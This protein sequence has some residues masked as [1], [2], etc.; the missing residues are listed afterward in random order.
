MFNLNEFI[1]NRIN[2]LHLVLCMYSGIGWMSQYHSKILVF[3]L[4]GMMFNWLLDD[5][6]CWM[7]RLEYYFY[8]KENNE[9]GFINK[10]LR[11]NNI[12]LNDKIID[13][14]ISIITYLLFIL[15]YYNSN[16]ENICFLE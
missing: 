10:I 5:N 2:N 16:K 14:Y 3:L 7:T 8:K 11:K 6:R 9:I 13:K 15:S 4:P 1:A 12:V